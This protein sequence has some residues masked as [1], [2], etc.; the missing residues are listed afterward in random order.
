[1]QLWKRIAESYLR[2]GTSVE[3]TVQGTIKA[4]VEKGDIIHRWTRCFTET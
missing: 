2:E 3:T 1:M 4:T